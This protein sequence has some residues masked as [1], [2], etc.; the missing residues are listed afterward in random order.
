MSG[1]KIVYTALRFFRPGVR[2]GCRWLFRSCFSPRFLSLFRAGSHAVS[3]HEAL[4]TVASVDKVDKA[5]KAAKLANT[6]IAAAVIFAFPALVH[7]QGAAPVDESDNFISLETEV[8]GVET[9]FDL[10]VR[11]WFNYSVQAWQDSNRDKYG[12]LAFNQ[13]QLIPQSSWGDWS[14]MAEIRIWRE[15]MTVR[16]A[17]IQYEWDDNAIQFGQIQ[18]PWGKPDFSSDSFWFSLGW[19]ATIGDN[20]G[21]GLKYTKDNDRFRVDLAYTAADA[22][23]FLDETATFHSRLTRRDEQQNEGFST[24]AVRAFYKFHHDEDNRTEFGVTGRAGLMDNAITGETGSQY[25]AAVSLLG[26][27]EGGWETLLQATRYEFRP[28]NPDFVDVDGILTPVD[29]R[30]VRVSQFNNFRDIA[31]KANLYNVNVTKTIPVNNGMLDKV[32]AYVNY[33]HI[34]KDVDEFPDSQLITPGVRFH[35][36]PL[37]LWFDFIVGKNAT[38]LNDSFENS[39]LA[40]G[41]N[42]PDRWE[43]RPNL[44]IQWFF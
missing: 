31:A 24:G 23:G 43:F 25:L 15:F 1:F 40:A 6:A 34:Q 35:M 19:Y 30:I 7:A 14:A 12:N 13:F 26:F 3:V 20:Y 22:V 33:S 21:Y 10:D 2:S 9:T 27:Y 11:V 28:E 4:A 44:Q 16:Q 32:V 18:V 36:G 8:N 17:W 37:R 38:F 5:A 42:R 29:D 39:G 41:A